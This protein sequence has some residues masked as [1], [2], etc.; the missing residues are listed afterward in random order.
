V[1]GSLGPAC[2]PLWSPGLARVPLF[3]SGS[4][5]IHLALLPSDN[6]LFSEGVNL[7]FVEWRFWEPITPAAVRESGDNPMDA[8]EHADDGELL[9][10]LT[11][12]CR[13]I[14]RRAWGCW[15]AC[16]ATASGG[17]GEG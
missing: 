11:K 14:L 6:R 1:Y 8:T 15:C 12:C 3:P 17:S 13:A 5:S 7:P 4:Q 16:C 9:E 2:G 10:K